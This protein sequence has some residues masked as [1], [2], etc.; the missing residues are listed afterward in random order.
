MYALT[1]CCGMRVSAVFLHRAPG[2]RGI[3]KTGG[4]GFCI[5]ENC[6]IVNKQINCGIV[7]IGKKIAIEPV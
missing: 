7:F 1:A 5:I 2:T 6:K 3:L 4:T